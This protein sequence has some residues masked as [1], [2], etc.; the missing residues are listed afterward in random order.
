[1][2]AG[3]ARGPRTA[4][5]WLQRALSP[6]GGRRPSPGPRGFQ[7]AAAARIWNASAA[8]VRGETPHGG[9]PGSGLRS[10]GHG[11]GGRSLL[12]LPRQVLAPA[13]ATV[14]LGHRARAAEAVFPAAPLPAASLRSNSRGQ[15][16]VEA[17]AEP[18]RVF[19]ATDA[20]SFSS[21]RLPSLC[22][23]CHVPPLPHFMLS[24]PR[25]A[26]PWGGM[27]SG[28]EQGPQP[29]VLVQKQVR[30]VGCQGLIIRQTQGPE[31]EA[32]MAV[33]ARAGTPCGSRRE[34]PREGGGGGE[35]R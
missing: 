5:A 28:L 2:T 12:A 32:D 6:A 31:R 4:R 35:R 13:W 30:E 19:L 16:C 27:N 22:S 21:L 24:R 10:R 33:E 15:R 8:P 7:A 3:R 1:M 23:S 26:L 14:G 34:S 25:E 29:T 17:R 20:T 11:R 9:A 18:G